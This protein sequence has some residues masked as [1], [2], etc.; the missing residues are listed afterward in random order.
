VRALYE[1]AA[2][3][4]AGTVV[5]RVAM[6]LTLSAA[7][8]TALV[9]YEGSEP[10][11]YLD[12][13]GIPT[14]CVGHTATVTRADVGK[15]M[16]A[17]CGRLLASDSAVAQRDVRSAV[18]VKITQA[19]YDAL[20]S[21]TF[22]VGGGN[23]RSST[24]LR[25]LNAGDCWGAGAEFPRWNRAQGRVL[26]GLIKRRAAERQMFETGCHD[27]N[28]QGTRVALQTRDG[29]HPHPHVPG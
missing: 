9:G 12:P 5:R 3:L 11:V 4:V 28:P 16:G 20:V 14:V 13:V 1:S 7:G 10:V 6:T 19:Q 21:F 17:L 27:R 15:D 23:L 18:M 8:A 22:N 26:P 24:L 25:K 2:K 29:G